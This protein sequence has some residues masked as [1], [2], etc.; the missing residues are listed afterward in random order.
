MLYLAGYKQLSDSSD[1]ES[2]ELLRRRQNEQQ[3]MNNNYQKNIVELTED[4]EINN[5]KDIPNYEILLMASQ[6]LSALNPQTH[7]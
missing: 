5:I 7:N 3:Q 4:K 1:I 2:K 6:P